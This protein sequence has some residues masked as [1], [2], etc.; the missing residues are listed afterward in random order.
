MTIFSV[1]PPSGSGFIDGATP[2]GPRIAK[3]GEQIIS[4]LH[5]RYYEQASRGNVFLAQAIV[6]APVIFSTAAGTGGPLLW[7]GTSTVKASILAVGWGVSTVSTVAAAIGLTGGSGQTSAP[8]ATTA[9]DGRSSTLMG[10]NTSACT[11]YRVGTVS[12]AGTFLFPLGQLNTGALTTT[13]GQLNWV[14][15]A[16]LF[17][18]PQYGWISLAASATAS[19]TVVTCGMIWEEIPV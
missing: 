11:P 9:I 5:G 19:T 15:V 16:G 7:N 17:I 6:T 8:T 3:T 14:E 10:G 13:P 12:S 2:S 18:L 4:E 1:G